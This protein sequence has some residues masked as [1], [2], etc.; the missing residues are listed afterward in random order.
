MGLPFLARIASPVFAFKPP[1][2]VQKRT[3]C[4][5]MYQ[6]PSDKGFNTLRP[7][8]ASLPAATILF[9][10]VTVFASCAASIPIFCAAS[11]RFMEVAITG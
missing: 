8:S 3:F 9:Q 2:V 7:K 11:A 4:S 10:R 1:N 6:G 5:T